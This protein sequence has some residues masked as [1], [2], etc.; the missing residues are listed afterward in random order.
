VLLILNAF[1]TNDEASINPVGWPSSW[2]PENFIQA[3]VDGNLGTAVRNSTI[4]TG[5]TVLG[6]CVIAG[7]AAYA[8]AKMRM[9]GAGL[10]TAYF[11]GSTTI[12]A[13]LFLVPLYFLW[14][15]LHLVD[16]ILGVIIIYLAVFT[17]F[18]VFLL[19][20][21]FIAL[22]DA[23]E[24]AARVDGASELQVLWHIVVP[25]AKPAFLTVALIVGMWSWNEFL[26][27]VTFLHSPDVQ[28]AA[29]SY[30]DFTNNISTAVA[31]QNAAGLILILPIVLL[32]VL[33]Q[34]RFIEGMTSGG[35]KL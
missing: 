30:Q 28:T 4:V 8:I 1:K 3:W 11:L 6:V 24:D 26:Y 12:P 27:A 5:A 23:I 18:S 13:Q 35:L 2:H 16:N 21:Y 19:R 34:R 20:A 15:H 29:I 14:L 22:P 32:Y 31:E 25:L 33:L 10:L 9:P 17:P 7:L